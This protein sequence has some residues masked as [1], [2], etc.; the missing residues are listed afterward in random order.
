MNS[1]FFLNKALNKFD[2][3]Y[4]SWIR[5]LPEQYWTVVHCE[6]KENFRFGV[7]LQSAGSI[8]LHNLLWQND[9]LVYLYINLYFYKN[10]IDLKIIIV[11][12]I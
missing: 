2:F 3:L 10:V 1:P 4:Q 12:F 11:C 8:Y 6:Q 5:Q 9:I 7:D